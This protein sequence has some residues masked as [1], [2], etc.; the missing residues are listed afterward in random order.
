MV[1][2][3]ECYVSLWVGNVDSD[4][5]L[6]DYVSV[7]YEDEESDSYGY[8]QFM[9]DFDIDELD[10]DDMERIFHDKETSS[11]RE[12]LSGCSYED[13]V[14][15]K[16]EKILSDFPDKNYNFAILVYDMNYDGNITMADDDYYWIKFI[17]TVKITI[18]K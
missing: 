6:S 1:D 4:E 17:D 5:L 18:K 3:A 7:N 12:L 15:L 9:K 2:S 8:S 11:L 14:I 10:E 16:F 13:R